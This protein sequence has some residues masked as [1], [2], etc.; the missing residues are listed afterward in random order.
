MWNDQISVLRMMKSLMTEQK[1]SET[2]CV[3]LQI[4]QNNIFV[5][6]HTS[7]V[8]CCVHCKKKKSFSL[9]ISNEKHLL[10]FTSWAPNEITSKELQASK[11]DCCL[12]I[13]SSLFMV[14]TIKCSLFTCVG[15]MW[16]RESGGRCCI[17]VFVVI[18]SVSHLS[19]ENADFPLDI[20]F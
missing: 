15:L 1:S 12:Q 10:Y 4:N 6:K 8:L 19:F 14:V 16:Q 9:H 11:W 3:Q 17:D 18:S 7:Y 20:W 13:Q 2:L 5:L